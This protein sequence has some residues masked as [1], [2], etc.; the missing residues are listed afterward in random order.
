MILVII[1]IMMMNTLIQG[2]AGALVKAVEMDSKVKGE[3]VNDDDGDKNVVEF[4]FA[5][6]DYFS[7]DIKEVLISQGCYN[8]PITFEKPKRI[9]KAL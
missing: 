1:M 8:A 7:C 5:D 9:C 4:N 6:H 3:E 2:I